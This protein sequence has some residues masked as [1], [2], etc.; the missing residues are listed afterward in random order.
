MN[1]TALKCQQKEPFHLMA[2]PH[3]AICNLDCSYC[4]YLE[5]ENLFSRP[6]KFQM[7]PDVME[8]YVREYINAHPANTEVNFAWQGGEPTLSGLDFFQKAVALQKQHANGRRVS[9]ALQTNG[10]LLDDNWAEFLAREDFLVGISIDGP[11]RLHDHYRV[12]KRGEA[13]FERVMRGLEAL[14]RHGVEFN[15]LTVVSRLNGDYPLKVYRFLKEIGSKYMQFIPLVERKPVNGSAERV[16][17]LAAPPEIEKDDAE[18]TEW[19]V[20]PMQFGRF[21][22]AIFDDW[23]RRDV[24]RY[25][26]NYFDNALAAWSGVQPSMCV[27]RETC[28]KALIIEH[29]GSVYSCDHFMYPEYRLGR[30]PEDNLRELVDSPAQKKFG[31]DKFDRLPNECLKCDV[32]FACNGECPKHRFTQ[33]SSGEDGL[34]YLCAGLKHYFH[35]VAPYMKTMA[36]LLRTGQPPAAI[37]E[38]VR[39]R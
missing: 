34:N 14:K 39:R 33:T 29:D 18:V 10:T 22:V 12:D 25:F 23:V 37:M 9:N 3:G 24:G 27:F 8:N 4:F 16:L 6:T 13:T 11:P 21:L 32:L 36:D 28:G 31:E 35:H 30:I 5:K 1:E 26:V 2:K 17:S 7:S 15:T 38:L 19:S 20:E